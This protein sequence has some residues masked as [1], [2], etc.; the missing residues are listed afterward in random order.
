MPDNRTIQSY[1]NNFRRKLSPY[2]TSG[3]GVACTVYPSTAPGAVLEF[4]LGKGQQNADHFARP[5]ANV[6]AS[7]DTIPQTAFTDSTGLSFSG[8]SMVIEAPS[9]IIIIKG[10]DSREEWDEKATDADVRKVLKEAKKA[11]RKS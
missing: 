9:R 10:D 7:L 8:T 3:V 1:V 2:L 6:N 5:R 4:S 11:L